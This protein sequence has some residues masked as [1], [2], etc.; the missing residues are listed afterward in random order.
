MDPGTGNHV[1]SSVEL[2]HEIERTRAALGE[3]LTALN[4]EVRDAFSSASERMKGSIQHAREAVSPSLQFHRHP[5]A[6]CAAALVAG[7]IIQRRLGRERGQKVGDEP[8]KGA[9]FSAR[10]GIRRMALEAVVPLVSEALAVW[11][12]R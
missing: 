8:E 5:W 10:P 7:F 2:A 12:K 11:R 4:H 3:K 9:A 6:F 1:A